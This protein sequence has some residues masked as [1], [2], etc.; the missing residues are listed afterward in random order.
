MTDKTSREF[1]PESY[2]AV[3]AWC[4]S[5]PDGSQS[6]PAM[7]CR[8][9]KCRVVDVARFDCRMMYEGDSWAE[10]LSQISG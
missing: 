10:V 9:G 8:N 4:R 1:D 7:R 2:D 3:L 5:K 6:C